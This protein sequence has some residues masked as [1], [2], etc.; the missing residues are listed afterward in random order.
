MGHGAALVLA[1][2]LPRCFVF[3]MMLIVVVAGVAKWL[4]PRVVVS[5]FVGSNPII[6]PIFLNKRPVKGSKHYQQRCS[7]F[8]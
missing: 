8:L 1:R 5:V 6:R 2:V 7:I 3:G 4:R